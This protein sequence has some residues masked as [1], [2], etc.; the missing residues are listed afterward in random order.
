MRVLIVEDDFS[1]GA[2]LRRVLEEE[3]ATVVVCQSAA[4]AMAEAPENFDVL[5][6]DWMLPDADGPSFCQ[7]LRR[8]NIWTPILMLTARGEVPDRVEGL[9]AGADDYLSKPFD[10]EELLARLWALVR[11]SALGT[12]LVIG[13]LVID[14][15][16][17]RCTS[18]GAVI[19]LTARE[20][21]LLV[22]LALANGDPVSRMTLL[23]DVWR[24]DF[25]PGSGVLDVQVSRLRDKLGDESSRIETVRGV[26]YRL[27]IQ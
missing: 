5:L 14:R 18:G 22:R 8:A 11:R 12:S 2:L 24:M 23:R 1:L 16:H 13:E 9:R 6:L 25:D 4:L 21:E 7:A 20:Y 17:R 15:L 27:R 3:G 10:V 26:G 19:D